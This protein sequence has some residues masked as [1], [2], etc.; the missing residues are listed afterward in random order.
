MPPRSAL[1][2]TKTQSRYSK[3]SVW[4]LPVNRTSVM[5]NFLF[6]SPQL[7]NNRVM[8]GL[9]CFYSSCRASSVSSDINL[10]ICF[11]LLCFL[12]FK[13]NE[14]YKM[15][16]SVNCLQNIFCVLNVNN[17]HTWMSSS[18]CKHVTVWITIS[19]FEC[20]SVTQTL[21]V[22]DSLFSR[23]KFMIFRVVKFTHQTVNV[24]WSVSTDVWDEQCDE[25]RRDVVKYRT[26]SVDLR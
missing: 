7:R 26:V 10:N 13:T 18:L 1:K 3:L 21:R 9:Q 22:R 11:V 12:I 16:L 24:W 25:F 14:F 2:W 23:L 15:L 19:R 4:D 8:T 5:T 6:L 20:Q 17:T